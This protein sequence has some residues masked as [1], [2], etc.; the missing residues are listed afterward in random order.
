MCTLTMAGKALFERFVMFLEGIPIII[1]DEFT[2]LLSTLMSL[3]T[4]SM[5]QSPS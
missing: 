4:H 2:V 5:E 1:R 3:L